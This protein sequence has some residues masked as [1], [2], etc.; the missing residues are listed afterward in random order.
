MNNPLLSILIPTVVG[1]EEQFEILYTKLYNQAMV[2]MNVYGQ[3]IEFIVEKDNKEI[4]I[5]LKRNKLYSQANGVFSFMPD[6]DDDVSDDAIEKMVINLSP[7]ID[8]LTYR[9]KCLING[10]YKRSNHSLI[11]TKWQDN[12]DGYDYT[13]SPFYKDV[14]KTEIA[15]SVPFKD[16]RWNEDEQW[17]YDLIPHLKNERHLDE[18]IYIYIYNET[19]PTERYGLD[20]N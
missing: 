15:K 8:C 4:S 2:A 7:D 11:Y 16:L 5:G 13:R 14:I 10:E 1:R 9:E 17:S 19:N 20:K 18:E 3:D 6:D 12:F